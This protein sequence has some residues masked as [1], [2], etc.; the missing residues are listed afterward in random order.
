MKYVIYTDSIFLWNLAINLALLYVSS[1]LL[2]TSIK[3]LCLLG[4]AALTAFL[5]EFIYIVSLSQNIR[6]YHLFY[7]ASYF[8]MIYF[9]FFKIKRI[10]ISKYLIIIFYSFLL[11]CGTLSIFFSGNKAYIGSGCLVLI[12]FICFFKFTY[13]KLINNRLS[14]K[15]LYKICIGING[16]LIECIGLMDTGNSLK[17]SFSK[18]SMVVIDYRFM[19]H[20]LNPNDY[21]E[22]KKYHETGL[23]DYEKLSRQ[24][25]KFY[26]TPYHTIDSN[27]SLM[28][29]FKIQKLTFLESGIIYKNIPAG[30]SRHKINNKNNYQVLLNESLKPFREEH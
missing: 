1:K 22:I 25:I 17:D 14:L 9:Y 4:W 12:L 23:F 7:V 13:N 20:Y 16:N 30:I 21:A 2:N 24:E 8:F 3:I 29:T 26:P 27:F 5:T 28:P 6:F 11:C 18:K 19:K 15:K 10:S